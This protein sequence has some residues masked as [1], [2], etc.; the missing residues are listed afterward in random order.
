MRKL[1]I[2]AL[3]LGGF[4]ASAQAADLSVGSFKD[5]LPDTISLG[6]VTVYGTVDVGY[7]YQEHG[8]PNSP[9]FYTGMQYGYRGPRGSQS[10]I[11]NNALSQSTIGVKV[12]ESLGM[13]FA[14]IAKLET[15]FNPVS[16][17]LADA[18]QS[19]LQTFGNPNP[20]A[21]GDGGRCGQFLNGEAFGGIS[22]PMY[23]TLT[24]GRHN[25]FTT[26]GVGKYD[27]NHGSYA[28]SLIG[29]SGGT[30]A[31]V[32]STETSRWDNS[33]RYI[34][35]FGPAHAGVM[36]S[37]GGDGTSILDNAVS[38]NIGASYRGF[39]VDG[40]YTLQKGAVNATG[41]ASATTLAYNI[42]NNEAYAIMAK[43]VMQIGDG[44]KDDGAVSKLTFFGGYVHVNMSNPDD[45]QASYLNQH[46]IGGYQLTMVAA[47]AGFS[48]D[49][50]QQTAWA[51]ASY[52]TGPWTFTGAWYH[53]NQNNYYDG[54]Q[55]LRAGGD[56]D[57]VSGVIDYRFNKHF[58]VYS[59][60][61]WLGDSGAWN[62]DEDNVIAAT[63][64]RLKF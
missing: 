48:T 28:F 3:A 51:G 25:S 42:S 60:V 7:V 34:Y 4:T 8:Y 24:V 23:G 30:V 11:T 12:E 19:I 32:G 9:F 37:N 6:G 39:S 53:L 50:V 21:F 33:V 22:N 44:F 27:P 43:Y 52:E 55:N 10:N 58:D 35:Q 63:G 49:K 20:A 40:Y 62:H 31:G 41:P 1:L 29:Y 15:G 13:G 47:S 18:C 38:A 45:T 56:L 36:Y 54:N 16:G 5:P 64:L 61:T 14:A 59:G 2:C 57:W 26:S 17:E 46:T